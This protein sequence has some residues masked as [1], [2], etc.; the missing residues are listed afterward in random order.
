[1]ASAASI[2]FAVVVTILLFSVIVLGFVFYSKISNTRYGYQKKV[3]MGASIAALIVFFFAIFF[4]ILAA[5]KMKDFQY[6]TWAVWLGIFF[7]VILMIVGIV[8]I[9]TTYSI[10]TNA[11]YSPTNSDDISALVYGL[12]S[13]GLAIAV[14]AVMILMGAFA[15][16]LVY[17]AGKPI[18]VI[19]PGIPGVT[20]TR[21]GRPIELKEM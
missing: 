10:V 1:M 6:G 5:V 17:A 21:P 18:T 3:V 12:A 8:Y 19:V 16:Y 14:S 9:W 2:I 4:F 11:L 13:G 15:A 20:V 7:G